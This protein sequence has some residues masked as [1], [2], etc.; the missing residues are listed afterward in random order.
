V[1]KRGKK[2]RENKAKIQI[3]KKKKK[4]K[5][6]ISPYSYSKA[7]TKNIPLLQS[8]LDERMV[9]EQRYFIN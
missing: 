3:E 5:I 1:V 4:T 8:K 6:G 7:R 2:N 9:D